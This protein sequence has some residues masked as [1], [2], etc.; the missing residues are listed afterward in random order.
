MRSDRFVRTAISI[1]ITIAVVFSFALA[2]SQGIQLKDDKAS[3]ESRIAVLESKV[4]S[5]ENQIAGLDK[6]IADPPIRIVPCK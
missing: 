2:V 5:L 6:R 3:L 4:S 1:G